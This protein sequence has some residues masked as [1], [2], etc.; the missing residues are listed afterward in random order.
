MIESLVRRWGRI[1]RRLHPAYRQDF[2]PW[3]GLDRLT[4]YA[5]TS[6]TTF[7]WMTYE[8]AAAI[9]RDDRLSPYF[10]YRHFTRPKADGSLRHLA[11]PDPHLKA[12]QQAILARYLSTTAP[13]P[14][15]L[16]FRRGKSTADHAWAHAGAAI[17]ISADMQDFFPTTHPDRVERWWREFLPGQFPYLD[18]PDPDPAARLFRLLT[19]HRGGLPQG[20]PTSPALSNLVNI[21]LDLRLE[22]RAA[23]AG[24]RYTRY[25]DDLAFSWRGSQRPPADFERGV[26]ATLAEFGYTLHPTKGW[27]VYSASDEPTITG[28]V[29]TRDGRVALPPEIQQ[30]MQRLARSRDE[31]DGSRLAGY[32]AYAHMMTRPRRR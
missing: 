12:I 23:Q 1:R 30:T 27:R 15:A 7:Q 5:M 21:P 2:L 10:R 26:R 16:G 11:E 25:C 4:A 22:R 20:A 19:T 29:L 9:L 13:H 17:I 14:A 18:D 8:M 28:A 3:A 31:R 32:R 6:P 24:G